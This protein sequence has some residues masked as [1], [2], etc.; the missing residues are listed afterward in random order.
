MLQFILV[1]ILFNMYNDSTYTL[2]INQIGLR[3][4]II[5][6]YINYMIYTTLGYNISFNLFKWW[7]ASNEQHLLLENIEYLILPF[8][9][10]A[11]HMYN[12]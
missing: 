9:V 7:F 5:M 6:Y 12:F 1:F 3:Y 4:S 11:L 2:R 8:E 10:N